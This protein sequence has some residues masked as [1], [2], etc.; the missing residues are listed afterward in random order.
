CV[1][2]DYVL[3]HESMEQPL[4]DRLKAVLLEFYGADPKQSTDFARIINGRHFER[5]SKLLS[6]GEVVTGGET[7]AEQRYIAPTVL[8]GI[9]GAELVIADEIFGPIL[10]VLKVA[11]VDEAI[12]FINKRLK[13]LALYVFTKDKEISARVVVRTSSGG[14]CIN[15]VI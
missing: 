8:R 1:A 2:P 10:P 15:D 14:V 13:P 4:L 11:N 7:D 6:S 5:L 9:T 12:R 3:V